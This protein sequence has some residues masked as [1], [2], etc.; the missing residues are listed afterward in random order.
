MVYLRVNWGEL[1]E[2]RVF[3]VNVIPEGTL[4]TPV[5][6]RV[7]NRKIYYIAHTFS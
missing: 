7:I 3:R 1:S 5:M 4:R 6:S 2:I